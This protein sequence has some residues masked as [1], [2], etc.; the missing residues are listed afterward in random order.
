MKAL[1]LT[2]FICLSCTKYAELNKESVGLELTPVNMEISHLNDID[3]LV[4]QRKEEKITQSITFIVDLP[5]TRTSDLDF[6]I[7][8]KGVDSWILRVIAQRDSETQDLGSLYAPF[9]P[10]QLSRTSNPT[11]STSVTIKVF[12]AA[13][14]ASERFRLMKCP[15]F[16]HNKKIRSMGI[17]GDN[18]DFN[19]TFSQGMSYTEKSHLVELTP[20]AFNA[21]HSLVGKYYI[22]IAPY[23]SVKK[24][25]FSSF[26]R[27]P[28]YVEVEAED[29]IR[30]DSCDGI[31]PEFQ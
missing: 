9:R 1:I 22:E 7:D 20:S 8:Q 18:A 17:K 30:V 3:W 6:L 25:I 5:K 15:A 19:L 31:N 11:A 28:M 27:I 10:R 12:Y 2:L 16:N 23:N 13:A 26:K 21:G 4:G 29:S 14:Y 24:R